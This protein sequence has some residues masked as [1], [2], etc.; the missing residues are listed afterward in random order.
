MDFIFAWFAAYMSVPKLSP[1]NTI[2][3]FNIPGLFP[4]T[5]LPTHQRKNDS[6][7]QKPHTLKNGILQLQRSLIDEEW[8]FTQ[9]IQIASRLSSKLVQV[10]KFMSS[11]QHEDGLHICL[12]RRVYV[13]T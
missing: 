5:I 8:K 3:S 13:C 4:F 2:S 7:S 10:F 6:S 1:T 11:T 9:I 12:V